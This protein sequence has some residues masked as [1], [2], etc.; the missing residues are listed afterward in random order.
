MPQNPPLLG[1]AFSHDQD[2]Y[3]TLV[4]PRVHYTSFV[5]LPEDVACR[6]F[7]VA[8]RLS[9]AVRRICQPEAINHESGDAIS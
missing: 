7:L 4:A 1:M 6:V 8:Q 9:A 3:Q 5:E 2:P